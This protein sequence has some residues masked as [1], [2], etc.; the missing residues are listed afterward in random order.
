MF[1]FVTGLPNLK[2]EQRKQ[3]VEILEEDS[4]EN[5]D[6]FMS[7]DDE[8]IELNI[9]R[10]KKKNKRAS[11][12]KKKSSKQQNQGLDQDTRISMSIEFGQLSIGLRKKE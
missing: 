5:S 12:G 11:K 10:D 1:H 8:A 9:K 2:A 4:G 3:G 7:E 6:D